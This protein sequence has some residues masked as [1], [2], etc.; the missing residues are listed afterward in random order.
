MLDVKSLW[1]PST[2]YIHYIFR[3][4]WDIWSYI[5]PLWLGIHISGNIG[6]WWCIYLTFDLDQNL[7]LIGSIQTHN[8]RQKKVCPTAW[9]QLPPSSKHGKLRRN[10]QNKSSNRCWTG[11]IVKHEIIFFR[12]NFYILLWS[13]FPTRLTKAFVRWL[14]LACL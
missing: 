6:I 9:I 3:R 4:V 11:M 14:F 10:I 1:I 13:F 8:S 5:L 12:K 2:Y 7:S